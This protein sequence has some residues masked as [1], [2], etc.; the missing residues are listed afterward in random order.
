MMTQ[1]KIEWIDRGQ[2][3]QH[4]ANPNFPRGVAVDLRSVHKPPFCETDLPY[5]AARCGY[6]EIECAK[7]GL[8]VM[9][10]TAGRADDPRSVM[11]SC[12]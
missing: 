5:P 10:T 2:E 7:C 9:V 4:P 1:F 12:R 3:P 11:M 8:R 6:Y